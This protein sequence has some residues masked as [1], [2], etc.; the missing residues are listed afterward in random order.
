MID[1][2]RFLLVSIIITNKQQQ[3]SLL[4]YKLSNY[5]SSFYYI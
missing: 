3:S 2:D 1:I 4:E 5:F